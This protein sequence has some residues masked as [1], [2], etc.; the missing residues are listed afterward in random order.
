MWP[1]F[2]RVAHSRVSV[3]RHK[4]LVVS[5]YPPSSS[6]NY[7][8]WDLGLSFRKKFVRSRESSLNSIHCSAD[9]LRE[10]HSHRS[11]N[12][13][14]YFSGTLDKHYRF[15]MTTGNT[16]KVLLLTH[17]DHCR[18]LPFAPQTGNFIKANQNFQRLQFNFPSKTSLD[19]KM[20]KSVIGISFPFHETAH[21]EHSSR[22]RRIFGGL[23]DTNLGLYRS[24]VAK[25]I[26]S[27]P[28]I[29]RNF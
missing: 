23:H 9:I 20:V 21:D 16:G 14:T 28:S 10:L 26:G 25:Q 12:L 22:T 17:P 3:V 11:L 1:F 2:L 8:I 6:Q 27:N 29:D 7:F 4:I 24:Q 18:P 5:W 13:F 15:S 19:T